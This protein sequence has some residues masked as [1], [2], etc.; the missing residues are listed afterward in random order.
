MQNALV[1]S[2][3][4][5]EKGRKILDG[6]Q[7]LKAKFKQQ[8]DQ[9]GY[10]VFFAPGRIN[11]I[12]EYTDFNG[13]HVFPC[14][15]T[16]GTYA[17]AKKRGDDQVRM[18]SMNFPERGM[19]EF[20]L[21]DLDYCKEHDWANYPKGMMRYFVEAGYQI[22]SGV[23]VLFY[24]NVPNGA[25]LSSSAS[26]EMVTGVLLEG[27]Y[28]LQIDRIELIKLGKK[29]EN[30]FIGVNSGIMD[31]F[32][33]GM[34]KAGNGIIL[35]CQSLTYHYAPLPLDQHD[36]IIMNTNKRRELTDSKYNERRSEC[37]E[38][39]EQVRE[40]V[41]IDF[42]CDLDEDAFERY[43]DQISNHKAKKR[44]KHVVYENGRTL[45]ALEELKKGN[46]QEFGKLMDES[47]RSLQ[48]DFEV[49]GKELDALV[50]AAWK[51]PGVL[52]ARMVGAG[53]GGCA[54]AIVEKE[55]ADTFIRAVGK[56]YHEAI[57]YEATFYV[58]SIGDGAKEITK[59]V[60]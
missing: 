31:Q 19:V 56:N 22:S 14:A 25:G 28:D 15:L 20:P 48:E 23:D 45:K 2:L 8:F 32:A 29:V 40:V 42:L 60:L 44:A 12:G 54:I 35:N 53:F 37:D 59:E 47:H 4:I 36:I 24:G 13:G 3:R 27:I 17:L 30:H 1:E 50:A 41:E 9:E 5:Q 49:T 38:A 6:L 58:A 10:R 46:L 57:G 51:Q 26:I 55:W 34:G 39:L 43:Q 16:F 52:G 18:Y 33:V 21:S 7:E 11:L